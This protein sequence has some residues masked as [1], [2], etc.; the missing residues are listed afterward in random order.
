MFEISN[1]IVDDI[2]ILLS[3]AET[4]KDKA[5]IL[6]RLLEYDENFLEHAAAISEKYFEKPDTRYDV[7]QY[8]LTSDDKE[9]ILEYAEKTND[10]DKTVALINNL[11][12]CTSGSDG[13]D[14]D[15]IITLANNEISV[16]S[17]I[18]DFEFLDKETSTSSKNEIETRRPYKN[19]I[20]PKK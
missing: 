1:L 11:C 16:I 2:K 6:L 7:S 15:E 9:F 5:E 12:S 10:L 17:D 4:V 19:F 18:S 13:L 8:Y 3:K 14:Y 20:Y